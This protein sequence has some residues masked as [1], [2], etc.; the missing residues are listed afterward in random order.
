MSSLENL[1]GLY[2]IPWAVTPLD[3]NSSKMTRLISPFTI[4]KPILVGK[5][6]GNNLRFKQLD[7]ATFYFYYCFL[8]FPVCIS[9]FIDYLLLALARIRQ[10]RFSFFVLNITFESVYKR[11]N[12]AVQRSKFEKCLSA[13]GISKLVVNFV[14]FVENFLKNSIG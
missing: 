14:F 4:T 7:G 1:Y 3:Y 13:D 9:E 6:R 10:K 8:V 5:G 11:I 2:E 12:E